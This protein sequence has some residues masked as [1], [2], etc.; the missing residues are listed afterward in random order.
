MNV[1]PCPLAMLNVVDRQ[2]N[3]KSTGYTAAM[4]L[5]LASPAIEPRV[6]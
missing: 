6:V 5:K 3:V 1:C 2:T 4:L